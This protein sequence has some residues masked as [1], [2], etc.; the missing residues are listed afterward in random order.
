[1]RVVDCQR[2]SFSSDPVA[3]VNSI[4]IDKSDLNNLVNKCRQILEISGADVVPSGLESVLG[5]V[6]TWIGVV[7]RNTE[8][9]L[10]MRFI[11]VSYGI[12]GWERI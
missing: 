7:D 3:H 8:G 12:A 4:A 2:D 11:Q 10:N 1:V 6:A 5:S 9:L